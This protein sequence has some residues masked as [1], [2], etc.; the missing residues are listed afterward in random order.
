[1]ILGLKAS[2][3]D[4][5]VLAGGFLSLGPEVAKTFATIF[6]NRKG[7]SEEAAATH[8][9]NRMKKAL[10]IFTAAVLAA[11]TMAGCVPKEDKTNISLDPDFSVP[12]TIELDFTELNNS[13]IA[14]FGEVVNT[15]Y[16]FISAVSIDGNNEEKKITADIKAIDGTT[17]E[18][19]EH[20]TAALLRHMNDAAADQY[21]TFE[22]STEKSFGNLYDTYS[23]EIKITDETDDSEIYT[24][25][26]TPGTEIPL[27]PDIETYE[28][29]WEEYGKLL[30]EDIEDE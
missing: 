6:C 21:T 9:D 13:T 7:V 1:M 2:K 18:D 4:A 5:S 3:S 25:N 19:A 8:A 28:E 17:K 16:I 10:I 23:A 29:S 22:M 27:S 14:G 26:V 20:F 12:S 11:G 30:N 24:L 15:P